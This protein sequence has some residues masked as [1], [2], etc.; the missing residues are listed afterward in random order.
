MTLYWLDEERNIPDV[1]IQEIKQ[2]M[3]MICTSLIEVDLHSLEGWKTE[4][5]KSIHKQVLTPEGSSFQSLINYKVICWYKCHQE[6]YQVIDEVKRRNFQEIGFG[7]DHRVMEILMN[8]QSRELR[9][10]YED[11]NGLQVL[12]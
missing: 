5:L 1:T 2:R 4:R 6:Q 8:L 10:M 12:Y 9:W 3:I 11:P 7:N